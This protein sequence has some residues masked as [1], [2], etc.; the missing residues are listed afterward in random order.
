MK[1]A[2]GWHWPAF[3]LGP[4]WYVF[5]GMTSK[6]VWLLALC[7]LSAL[8]AVPFVMFYCGAKGKGDLYNHSL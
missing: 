8:L 5:N 2:G 6:G 4:F 1:R 7:I 3:F